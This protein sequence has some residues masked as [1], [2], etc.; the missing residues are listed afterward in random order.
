MYEE[1]DCGDDDRGDDDDNDK[2]MRAKMITL[3][4]QL[5]HTLHIGDET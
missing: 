1:N 4:C 5:L 3:I 2:Q